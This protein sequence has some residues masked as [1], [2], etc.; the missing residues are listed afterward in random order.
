M[1]FIQYFLFGAAVPWDLAL[2][3]HHHFQ[4][5]LQLF[6]HLI[7]LYLD[8]MDNDEHSSIDGGSASQQGK[9]DK[10]NDNSNNKNTSNGNNKNETAKNELYQVTI[11]VPQIT[12][13]EVQIKKKIKQ[14]IQMQMGVHLHPL[15]Q[16]F[17]HVSKVNVHLKSI[18]AKQYDFE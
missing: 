7:H 14:T 5:F 2:H 9:D 12:T 4:F 17:H 13:M 18:N 1:V 6:L 3:L 16:I 15:H 10:S 11:M 8:L